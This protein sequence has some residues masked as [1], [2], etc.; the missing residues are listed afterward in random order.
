MNFDKSKFLIAPF[1]IRVEKPWGYEIIYTGPE[2][3]AVGKI[4]HINAGKRLSLQYHDQK[5]ETLCLYKGEAIII[6]ANLNDELQEVKMEKLKGYST[7]PGQRHRVVAVT[8][9]EILESSMPEIGNTYRIEDDTN[10]STET[11]A[12]RKKNRGWK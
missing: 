3:P 6:L 2:A 5:I 11:E 12:E 10:R 1:S 4:L 9:C 7:S 8:D